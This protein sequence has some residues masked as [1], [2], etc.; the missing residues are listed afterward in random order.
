MSFSGN[1]KASVSAMPPEKNCC[2]RSELCGMLSY[3]SY[4]AHDG[5][6]FITETPEVSDI[7]TSLLLIVADIA[8]TPEIKTNSNIT[9]YKTEIKDK[10]DIEKLLSIFGGEENIHKIKEDMFRC[11]D[12]GG[13]Y[14]RGAFLAAGYVNSPSH[15]YHLE[16]STPFAD[17]A[18]ETAVLLS[19]KIGMPK[20]SARKSNQVIYYRE[21]SLVE[22]FLTLIGA[23]KSAL[24]IMNEQIRREMRNR[25][26]RQSN[27]E[28]ANIEKTVKAANAQISAIKELIASGRFEDMTD[29]MKEVAIIRLQ[30]SDIS[31][32]EI[33]KMLSPPVSKSQVSKILSKIMDFYEN[34][35]TVGNSSKT[36]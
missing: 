6:K 30:N 26:N 8:A 16:I 9:T 17:L 3:S 24:E 21:S 36:E 35:D 14:L 25:V 29:K 18:V 23:T 34:P 20:I 10:A 11:K 27:F 4:F 5:L 28:F 31:Q 19:K 1:T 22:D 2:A 13:A 32:S 15:S 7:F 33:G 12:C